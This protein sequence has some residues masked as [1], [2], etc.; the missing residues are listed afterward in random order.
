[1]PKLNT[2]PIRKVPW[3]LWRQVYKVRVEQFDKLLILHSDLVGQ[4]TRAAVRQNT[5]EGH[6]HARWKSVAFERC[7]MEQDEAL[8]EARVRPVKGIGSSGKKTSCET[9][10]SVMFCHEL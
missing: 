9:R 6:I 7:A 10:M 8:S 3:S 2:S 5:K 1:M 4:V